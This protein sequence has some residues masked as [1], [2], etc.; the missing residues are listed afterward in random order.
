MFPP[1]IQVAETPGGSQRGHDGPP[2]FPLKGVKRYGASRPGETLIG[3]GTPPP[4]RG[5]ENTGPIFLS[6][7]F[8][9][10]SK[11]KD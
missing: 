6:N 3:P 8:E 2:P 5:V 1:P 11:E 9:I 7:P 4:G 10:P